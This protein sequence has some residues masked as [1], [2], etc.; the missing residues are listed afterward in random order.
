MENRIIDYS[1]LE[2]I[3]VRCINVPTQMRKLV[4]IIVLEFDKHA[5]VGPNLC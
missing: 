3:L 1:Q 4:W 5:S 2:M